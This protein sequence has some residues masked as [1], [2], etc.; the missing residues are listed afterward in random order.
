MGL[1]PYPWCR[2][3]AVI[4]SISFGDSSTERK[5]EA[6]RPAPKVIYKALRKAVIDMTFG[7]RLKQLRKAAGESQTDLAI[8]L[9]KKA[10]ITI[11]G[12]EKGNREPN[13]DTI[14]S[15]CKHYKVSADFLLGINGSEQAS[16]TAKHS[17][18]VNVEL[19]T[20]LDGKPVDL[21]YLRQAVKEKMERDARPKTLYLCDHRAC[22]KSVCDECNLTSD[23]RH[24][25]NFEIVNGTFKER[26]R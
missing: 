5:A 21:E 3:A 14:R 17:I 24:A 26:G 11:S 25:K 15:I 2:P 6:L 9:E 10:A 7:E 22:D 20:L 18:T 16:K 8:I 19:S 12:Y 4:L 13:F 23:V 1:S